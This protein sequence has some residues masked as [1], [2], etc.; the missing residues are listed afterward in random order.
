MPTEPQ[1]ALD[2][3]EIERRLLD[4]IARE[5]M[6]E[7][8]ALT[9]DATFESLG[10]ASIDVVQILM[11][12]EEEFDIYV[13]VEGSLSEAKDVGGLLDGLTTYILEHRSK[14]AGANA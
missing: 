1:P 12:I 14:Q 10:V 8:E 4:I 7:R 11:G 9:T 2:R 3:A 13:P 5:G 6:I